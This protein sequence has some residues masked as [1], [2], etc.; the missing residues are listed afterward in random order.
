MDAILYIIKTACQ[1]RM[2]P[3]DFVPWQTVYYYFRKW[4]FEGVIE[5]IMDTLHAISRKAA[6]RDESPSLGIIDSR[7]VKTSHYA[8]PSCKGTDGNKKV[9]G[10]KEHV[11]VDTLDLP[12]AVSVHGA[13]VHDSKGAVTVI[14]RLD[15]RFPR[16]GR[17]LADGGYRGGFGD[18]VADRFGWDLEVVLRSDDC[19]SRFPV[20]PKRWSVE[21]SF[22]WLENFRRL[23]LDY[24]YLAETAE[25]IVQLA[26]SMI[27]LNKFFPIISKQLLSL[28]SKQSLRHVTSPY[29]DSLI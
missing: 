22:A 13:G 27:I 21:L 10:R 20:L 25:A 14:E 29:P 5:D 15:R 3:S 18:W 2:L 23:S 28:H 19:P 9:R 11:L 4:K 6:S 24:E 16:L 1:W 12:L 8:D 26:F 7:S 17:I